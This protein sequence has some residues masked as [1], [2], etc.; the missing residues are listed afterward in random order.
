MAPRAA[1][2]R[3]LLLLLLRGSA[4]RPPLL[5]L[6]LL[7]G[8]LG[9]VRAVPLSED[10]G[11]YHNHHNHH[12]LSNSASSWSPSFVHHDYEAMVRALRAVASRCPDVSRLYSIGQSAQGRHLYAMEMSDNPGTH[13][14][15]EPEFK[16]VGNMHGN[17]ALGRELLLHLLHHLCSEHRRGAARV[18][19]LLRSTRIHVLPS[20]NPDG[21][22]VA[23]AQS[24]GA[25]AHWYTDGRGNARGVDLNR[26]FPDLTAVF[27]QHER[28]GGPNHHLALPSGWHAQVQ[29]ETRA[30]IRWLRQHNFVL[31]ANLH[32]GAVVA[33]Y[34]FDKSRRGRQPLP[35][36]LHHYA[37]TPDDPLFRHLAITYSYAHGWMHTGTNC[38]DYFP[39]GITNGASWY[40][41]S[42]GMQD[43]NYLH[44]NCFEVTLELSC[45]K[46]PQAQELA[47]EW[48]ANREA[49]LSFIEQVHRGV[50]GVVRGVGGVALPGAQISVAGIA[51]D[52]TAGTDG[53]YFRLLLPGVYTLSASAPGH[54]TATADAIVTDSEPSEVDFHLEPLPPREKS[55]SSSAS[56]D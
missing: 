46:F 4:A 14:V 44:S 2:Q 38:G 32:G 41:L 29:P 21:Y 22:E 7:V 12:N 36:R 47:R 16:Y 45:E 15:G 52:I 30:V 31:S 26:D 8:W 18:Q 11:D 39:D 54:L 53:D 25:E 42:G 37:G 56:E 27:Y 19:R 1:P 23:A 6:L 28:G 5:L 40:S 49:L 55:S 3:L 43:F 34:P 33:N 13:E 17:E 50:K 20:M 10:G 24:Q 35:S 48:Q 51:H 9:S